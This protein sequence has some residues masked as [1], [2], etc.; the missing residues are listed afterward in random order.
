MFNL[1][2]AKKNILSKKEKNNKYYIEK[3]DIDLNN[4]NDSH[5]IIINNINFSGNTILDVGC[6]V[7]YIGR[8]IKE[9]GKC[10]ID[11]I[12]VDKDAFNIAKKYYD[13]V[14]N[15]SIED[16]DNSDYK[17]FFSDNKKYDY[18]IFADLLEHL[19]DPGKILALLYPKLKENGKMIISIPNISHIDIISNLINGNFN[20]N[21]TGIL[22]STHLRF[23]TENSFYD[24]IKNVSEKYN[25]KM[26]VELIGKTYAKGNDIN[27]DFIFNFLGIDAYVFQNIF[28]LTK[29]K[30]NAINKKNN[31][32][33]DMNDIYINK[34]SAVSNYIKR[35]KSLEKENADL[36][37]ETAYLKD[38]INSIVY[39]NSWKLTKPLRVVKVFINKMRCK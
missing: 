4:N 37:K 19:I 39:S 33:K 20:Y 31:F 3:Y 16:T 5:S 30:F 29:D 6:G 24:F 27:D 1:G 15:F 17:K 14:F 18:I 12:E 25:I 36:K 8:K 7:G 10:T 9:L 11:G 32:Y 28:V 22:D 38:E 13:N 26:N 23:F 35:I 2:N 21:E 34:D